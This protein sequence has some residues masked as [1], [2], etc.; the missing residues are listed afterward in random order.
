M[1]DTLVQLAEN[2]WIFPRDADSVRAQS[3][4]NV[5]IIVTKKHTI[6]V[7]AGNSPRH[8]RRIMV[9]LDDIQAPAVQNI[10]YTHCHWDHVFG[11]MVYGAPAIAHE[12]GQRQLADLATRPWGNNYVLEEIQRS[13]TRE[14]NL[15]AMMKA[16]EEWRNFRIVQPELVL[17]KAMTLYVDDVIIE[18]EHVGGTH[19]PDSLVV[20]LP[21]SRILFL[22]DCYYPPPL[23]VRNPEDTF[24]FALMRS[25]IRDDIDVYVDGHNAPMTREWFTHIATHEVLQPDSL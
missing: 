24:N 12:W 15:R 16:M 21:Q 25:L 9:A 5:G 4:P 13:P 6:L 18:I 1:V 8:A 2:V 19:S 23:H 11:A 14:P 22:G 20:R 17:T 3:Q 7:D 10:I